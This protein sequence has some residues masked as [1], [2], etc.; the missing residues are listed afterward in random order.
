MVAK[1]RE[2]SPKN[3]LTPPKFN[4]APEN[5]GFLNRNLLFQG[6]IFRVYVKL[7]EGKSG[8]GFRYKKNCPDEIS[9]GIHFG[10]D[11]IYP[12]YSHLQGVVQ[13]DPFL[14]GDPICK[15]TEFCNYI[16]V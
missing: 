7:P 13:W 9:N 11:E 14:G 5:G 1:V 10:G 6:S 16:F 2:V 15:C 3:G 8:E 12:T 4:I